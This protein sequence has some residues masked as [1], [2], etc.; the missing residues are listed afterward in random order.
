MRLQ[1]HFRRSLQFLL[2]SS[3][4]V[5]DVTHLNVPQLDVPFLCIGFPR[6]RKAIGTKLWQSSSFVC[7][8]AF[9]FVKHLESNNG[10]KTPTPG[11]RLQE[12][13]TSALSFLISVQHSSCS[14]WEPRI[15]SQ[16]TMWPKPWW[17]HC[18]CPVP[19]SWLTNHSY[20]L[21]LH[22]VF[23]YSVIL[24]ILFNLGGFSKQNRSVNPVS[25][26]PCKCK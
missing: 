7:G 11:S 1:Y 13:E 10:R 21:V 15:T 18:Q 8:A 2:P 12:Q 9:L 26:K 17:S 22:H 24:L 5:T 3:V 19:R 20:F 25:L 16:L 23:F 4:S 6:W 14:G